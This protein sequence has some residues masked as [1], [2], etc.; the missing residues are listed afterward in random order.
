MMKSCVLRSVLALA[1]L[2]AHAAHAF[3]PPL[4]KQ[5]GVTLRIEGFVEQ[6]T[7]ERFAAEKMPADKPL[8]FTVTLVNDRKE[9]VGGAVKVWLND[10]WQVTGADTQT[11]SAE[12]GKSVSATFSATA[13]PS[14]L[15]ALYPIHARLALTLDGKTVELHPIAIF[16]AEKSAS[17]KTAAAPKETAVPVGLLRLDAGV[18]RQVFSRQNNATRELG[19]NF[20]GADS[21]SGTHVS[22][23]K[24]TR[25]GIERS[26][27]AVHPPWRNGAGVTWNDFKLAL[28]ESKSIALS[29][30]TAIRDS[31]GSEGAS[32]GT[33][34][35]SE[36]RRVGKEC[37]SRWSPY[38]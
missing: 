6:S 8:A 18:D 35:R 26:G 9:T 2:A 36:E 12:P 20:N 7:P 37:R 5:E 13:K 19:V 14:V 28:P 30:H 1:L 29:F 3:L 4:D 34:H 32:D 10:D 21:V 17:T 38:H 24:V 25:G 15:A 27:I 23:D 22:R 16:E 11:L 33:E 31:S